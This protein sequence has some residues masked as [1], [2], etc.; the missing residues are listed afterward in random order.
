VKKYFL[1]LLV[2]T[3]ASCEEI[4]EK[5][6]EDVLS[7]AAMVRI[8]IDVHIAEAKVTQKGLPPDSAKIVFLKSKEEILKKNHV[9]SEAFQKSYDFYISH[10]KGME[11][12]YSA[13][14]DSLSLREAKGQID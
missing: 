2:L 12:I 1:I 5:A 6:P 4:D 8:L 10:L 11:D 14:V 3:F 7:K 9:K 13:V